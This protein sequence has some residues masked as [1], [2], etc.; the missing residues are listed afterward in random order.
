[1]QRH[2]ERFS[3][4]TSTRVN[5]SLQSRV[6]M[7]VNTNMRA[8]ALHAVIPVSLFFLYIKALHD[9]QRETLRIMVPDAWMQGPD[10]ILSIELF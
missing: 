9:A 7:L 10:V 5:P 2:Q 3:R 1:M 4:C 8:V 6:N